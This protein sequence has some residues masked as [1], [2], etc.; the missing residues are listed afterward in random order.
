MER[1]SSGGVKSLRAMFEGANSDAD[2]GRTQGTPVNGTPD[3][4]LSKV[5]TAFVE[6]EL[7]AQLAKKIRE[8]ATTPDVTKQHSSQKLGLVKGDTEE[9]GKE[10]VAQEQD[11]GPAQKVNG[12]RPVDLKNTKSSSLGSAKT[13]QTVSN[14]AAVK[15]QG[16]SAVKQDNRKPSAKINEKPT[17]G[18]ENAIASNAARKAPQL[19]SNTRATAQTTAPAKIVNQAKPNEST[20]ST[21]SKPKPLTKP[22]V[23]TPI[24]ERTKLLPSSRQPSSQP[25]TPKFQS[26]RPQLT[27]QR[28]LSHLRS[29]NTVSDRRP[30]WGSSAASSR[31]PVVP[32]S[33]TTTQSTPVGV[34]SATGFLKPR[35]RSPTRPIHLPSHL[36]MHTASSAAKYSDNTSSPRPPTRQ[37]STRRAS[38]ISTA[39]SRPSLS[40]LLGSAAPTSRKMSATFGP[41]PRPRVASTAAQAIQQRREARTPDDGFLARMMRPT[42]SS[43]SKVLGRVEPAAAPVMP[44]VS[45]AP[46]KGPTKLGAKV[47]TQDGEGQENEPVM[48]QSDELATEAVDE[49]YEEIGGEDQAMFT[50]SVSSAMETVVEDGVEDIVSLKLP[51]REMEDSFKPQE[52]HIMEETIAERHVDQE[53]QQ[54]TALISDVD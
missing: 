35:P 40:H 52:P 15:P 13:A 51:E 12:N 23:R 48:A 27:P 11:Q 14:N 21:V 49:S 24:P 50:A 39:S 44:R 7:S 34:R 46:K 37:A 17:P 25:Q 33:T 19:E 30:T 41:P 47:R 1:S 32:A 42:A 54:S 53:S 6:V 36:T 18:A 20:K 38:N 22:S 45:V 31:P 29:N 10:N 2:R 8:N 4:P 9:G 16:L 28:S 3:R 5:R 43:A 26:P